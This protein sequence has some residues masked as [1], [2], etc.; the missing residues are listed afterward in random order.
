MP[1]ARRL[2]SARKIPCGGLSAGSRFTWRRT[3]ATQENP[4][5]FL[6]TYASRLSPQGRVQHEPLGRA[7]QQYAGAKN[8]QALL[9]L[10][11]P[12][13]RAAERSTLVKELVESGDMYQPWRGRRAKRTASC[14]T[15]PIFE[16]SGLLV[17][18]PDWWK[19][20]H[21]ARPIVNVQIDRQRQAHSDVP[22]ALL[23]FSVG[24]ALDGETLTEAEIQ[25]LLASVD[26]LVRLKGKWVEVDREK[27]AE[28][29]EHWQTASNAA[30]AQ[31]GLSFFEGMRLLA[32]AA[33]ERDR[34]DGNPGTDARVDGFDGRPR[35]RSD[36]CSGSSLPRP[37]RSPSPPELAPS[38][39]LISA[40][41]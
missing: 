27:L 26:G 9:S 23:D 41:A 13:Q 18:V 21:P 28:A 39:G 16:E 34:L 25:E 15:F 37:A 29:L 30:S 3:N 11:V 22:T 40:P 14:K 7:L 8:R 38:C 10:L 35:T 17:R 2:I 24:V 1:A 19:P 33:L 31:A 20:R 12:L 32:G 5:A 4:F 36:C 6:A